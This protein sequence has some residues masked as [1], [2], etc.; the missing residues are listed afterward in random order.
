MLSNNSYA[1]MIEGADPISCN[2]G[3][4]NFP[5]VKLGVIL[6]WD[7]PELHLQWKYKKRLICTLKDMA[8]NLM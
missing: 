7:F 8:T 1:L 6:V 2:R 5:R 4:V 3:L